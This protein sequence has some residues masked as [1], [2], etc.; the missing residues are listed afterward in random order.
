MTDLVHKHRELPAQRSLSSGERQ[1]ATKQPGRRAVTALGCCDTPNLDQNVPESRSVLLCC[2]RPSVEV[3]ETTERIQF[4]LRF[5][6]VSVGYFHTPPFHLPLSLLSSWKQTT[7]Q[8]NKHISL[9]VLT[10]IKGVTFAQSLVFPSHHQPLTDLHAPTDLLT[11]S[12]RLPSRIYV[13]SKNLSTDVY[14]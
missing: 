3:S 12:I 7:K 5:I 14:F 8:T 11:A 6:G 2:R 1:L 9:N 13:K 10:L 4:H